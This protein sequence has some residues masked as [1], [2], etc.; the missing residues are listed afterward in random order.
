[1]SAC[2]AVED[3]KLATH[4]VVPPAVKAAFKRSIKV[5]CGISLDPY[6]LDMAN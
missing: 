3:V 1:M 6:V 2:C 4:L 5:M